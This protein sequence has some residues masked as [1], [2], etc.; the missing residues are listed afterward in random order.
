MG[1][2]P[3]MWRYY[4]ETSSTLW[5]VEQWDVW[6]GQSPLQQ[7]TY[8]IFLPQPGK[9][10][11]ASKRIINENPQTTSTVQLHPASWRGAAITTKNQTKVMQDIWTDD[12]WMKRMQ[13]K[14]HI[15][16]E[17]KEKKKSKKAFALPKKS[18][19]TMR[20][21]P[22]EKGNRKKWGQRGRKEE[23]NSSH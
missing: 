16:K 5:G 2:K 17:R 9:Q 21:I 18:S 20:A 10:C 19:R 7:S 3:A 1:R 6:C 22:Y 11:E 12:E 15:K 13:K 23:K 4:K 14:M 8:T